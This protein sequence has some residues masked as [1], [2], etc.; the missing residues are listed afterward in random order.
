MAY[1]V[2]RLAG[3]PACQTEH[4]RLW[5]DGNP[6]GYQ[7]LIEQ[8]N[9][10]FLSHNKR[11][12]SGYLYKVTYMAQGL[13]GQHIK[14]TRRA[15]GSD[16][17]VT[18]YDGLT[19]SSGAEQWDFIQKNFNVDEFINYYAVNMCIQN[20]DG[21]FNNYYLYH[22]SGT[23]GKWEMYPWDEDKT[24]GEYDG[25]S[26]QYDWYE[27]PL[28]FGSGGRQSLGFGGFG[29]GAG[30]WMR[31]PGWFSGP[32]LANREF[33]KVF[34]AR[35]K[36]ICTTVFT[37]PK[38]VPLIDAMEKRLTPEVAIRAELVGESKQAAL[39]QFHDEIQSLRNQVKHRRQF[40]L[41][42][43]PKDPASQ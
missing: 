12:S 13:R 22:D 35:L 16:D 15:T 25:C 43:I 31:P 20:W 41:Q 4:V 19:R 18:L 3:N 36:E 32:L 30:G 26:P 9:K 23:T 33:R 10:G 8:P 27:M 6:R 29:F 40:I 2:Y 39:Q 7:L 1:E 37:E 28:S 21:F 38:M 34:L 11:D 17:L 5:M 14:K 42:Q 24:W